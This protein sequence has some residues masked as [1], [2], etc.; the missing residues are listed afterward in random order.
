MYKD[1]NPVYGSIYKK[2]M[3]DEIDK[4]LRQ[5]RLQGSTYSVDGFYWTQGESDMNAAGAAG[6]EQSL[7]AFIASVRNK[8]GKPNLKFIIA[9]SNY[10]SAEEPYRS[11]VR[12][13]QSHVANITPN[14]LWVDTDDIK[15]SDFVHYDS[16]GEFLLGQRFANKIMPYMEKTYPNGLK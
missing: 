16:N 13:A 3:N 15:L 4:A 14:V 10:P 8:F 6:Y 11:I 7:K 1:W 2:Y 9:R 12:K 5:I